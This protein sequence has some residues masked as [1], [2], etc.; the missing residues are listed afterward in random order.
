MQ[1]NALEKNVKLN[2]SDVIGKKG[3]NTKRQYF[4]LGQQN[5]THKI[6]MQKAET[7]I[8]VDDRNY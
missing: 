6:T 7:L 5:K 1:E 3:R 4:R 8:K 2:V